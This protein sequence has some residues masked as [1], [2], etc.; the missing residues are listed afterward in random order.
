MGHIRLG[1]LLATKRWREVV[2][3]LEGG[4][5]VAEVAASAALAAEGGLKFAAGDPLVLFSLSLLTELPLAARGPEF[6]AD[7]R[8]LGL[9]VSD[10]PSLIELTAAFSRAV[11]EKAFELGGRS[12]LGEIGQ[13]AAVE[14]V[15]RV[16]GAALPSLFGPRTE[17]VQHAVGRLASGSGFALLARCFFAQLTERTLNFYLSRAL[18][19]HVGPGARFE[20]DA[21]RQRFSND[22]ARHCWEAAEIVEAFA[23]GWYGKAVY[24]EGGI[25]PAKLKGF[26][27]YALRKIRSELKARRDAEQ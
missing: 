27:A 6:V 2:A 16:V 7:L 12:D 11:D 1:L 23:G 22:L 17:D 13:M 8:A 21:A 15:N 14:S 25:T 19:D 4:G 18:P 10:A 5:N 26:S 20:D 9:D 24:Q 3:T